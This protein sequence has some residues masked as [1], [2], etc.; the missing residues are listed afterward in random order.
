MKPN[1]P[2][3]PTW[4]RWMQAL[5]ASR[6]S[7]C[8]RPAV[9]SKWWA[10]RP[11]R[12]CCAPWKRRYTNSCSSHCC[13]PGKPYPPSSVQALPWSSTS[14]MCWRASRRLRSPC[15]RN[16]VKCR[17]SRA[18][19]AFILRTCGPPSG[20]SASLNLLCPWRPW[21]T[22]VRREPVSMPPCCRSSSPAML[23][24]R[25]ACGI[26]VWVL[27]RPRPIAACAPSGR[28][29]RASSKPWPVIC[30]PRMYMSNGWLRVCSCSTPRSPRA[31]TASPIACYR[32]C[33]FLRTSQH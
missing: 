17:R 31:R 4:R 2:G 10:W 24:P 27:P 33:F 12:C 6:A 22:G 32:T 28:F 16:T 5:C 18:P 20:V 15:F 29:A 26:S 14:S 3:N 25:G 21:P 9:P 30:C 1:I 23:A 8:T 11:L 19:S 7:S 13:A